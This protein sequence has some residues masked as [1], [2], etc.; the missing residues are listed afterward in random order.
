MRNRTKQLLNDLKEKSILE[1][2]SS[3][4]RSHSPKN[5]FGRGCRPVVRKCDDDD[6]PKIMI[7]INTHGTI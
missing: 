2:E 1:T 5:S 4:I 3:S 7:M 6:Y